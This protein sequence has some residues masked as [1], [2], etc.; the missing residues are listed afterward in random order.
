MKTDDGVSADTPWDSLNSSETQLATM[1]SVTDEIA[2]IGD[3]A[4]IQW[5][6]GKKVGDVIP[7][8]DERG[9]QFNVRIVGAVAN[10]I[11]QGSLIIDEAAFVKRFPSTSGYRMFLIDAPSNKVEQVSATLSRALRDVGLELTPAEKRLAAF[12]AVQNTYLSTF[13][14]LGGLGLL[15]GSA[16]MGIV[17]LR[18]VLE[19]RGELAVLLAVGW[20][21]R[22]LRWL[23]LSE[24]A[25]LL[26]L[27]IGL[28]VAAALVA[29]LPALLSPR[30][31]LPYL[32]LGLTL[33]AVL[34]SGMIW[35]WAAT[36][37]AL[38]GELLEAL[39]NN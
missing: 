21:R 37:L 7:Y 3:A 28:G 36:S 2:A 1:R 11:L 8:T 12:N 17:V 16:G 38:R 23:V 15:L 39:R 30:G 13:Q 31:E 32:S 26:W 27:G 10:S 9:N 34:A 29:V 33:G 4:S 18:N 35:T 20:R 25:A 22:S 6:L 19:R 5:A 24:H 14:I